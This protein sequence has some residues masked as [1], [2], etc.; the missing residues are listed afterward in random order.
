[1]HSLVEGGRRFAKYDAD[2]SDAPAAAD[3]DA[4]DE[5]ERRILE[6]YRARVRV[7]RSDRH[8]A[9]ARRY[10]RLRAELAGVARDG[11]DRGVFEV[12]GETCR[13]APLG[14]TNVAATQ[15]FVF[16]ALTSFWSRG[17]TTTLQVLTVDVRDVSASAIARVMSG[18]SPADVARGLEIWATFPCRIEQ[19]VVIVPRR[20][21]LV[22][23]LT[24]VMRPFVPQKVWDKTR[25][26]AAEE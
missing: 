17:D 9:Y 5:G 14:V 8:E 12:A 24:G 13:F 16:D 1:M 6:T 25:F 22:R 3:G 2:A 26:V 21:W 15:A 7:G 19:V 18:V 23:V 11:A 10:G 4:L 20:S